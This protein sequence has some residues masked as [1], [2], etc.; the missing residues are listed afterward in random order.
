MAKEGKPAGQTFRQRFFVTI[1]T[2]RLVRKDI[3]A[4]YIRQAVHQG[5]SKDG[6][7]DNIKD[8]KVSW[9]KHS[10]RINEPR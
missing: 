1:E 10:S 9:I 8:V 6:L 4:E 7:A 2:E 5:K 3:Y